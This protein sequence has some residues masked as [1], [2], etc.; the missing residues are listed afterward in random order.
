MS[1]KDSVSN[2]VSLDISIEEAFEQLDALIH[3]LE[4]PEHSLEASFKA[5]EPLKAVSLITSTLLGIVS[6]VIYELA[7]AFFPIS[8]KFL[9]LLRSN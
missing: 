8:F 1:K 2:D 4:Q 6:D 7:N 5:F 3:E 9:Q